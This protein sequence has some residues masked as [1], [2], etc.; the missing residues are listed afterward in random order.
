MILGRLIRTLRA[1][2]LSLIPIQWVTK[3]FVT[4]DIISFTL[5][6]GGGGIQSAGTLELYD[7]G[8]KIIIAGLFAQIAAFSFFIVVTIH[9]H[10]QYC[11]TLPYS[12]SRAKMSWQRHLRVLYTTSIVILVRSIFRVVEYLQGNGGYLISHEIFLYMFDT[13]LMA[14]VMV[15][16]MIWYVNDLDSRT[17]Q[18]KIREVDRS[19]DGILEELEL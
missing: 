15:I 17:V 9:F 11:K 19:S 6:A 12:R 18:G 1:E 2:N 8:E 3:I 10:Y 4:G 7:I 16:F 13:V 5:Q 14:A